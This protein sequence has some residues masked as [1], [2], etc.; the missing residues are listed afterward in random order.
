MTAIYISSSEAIIICDK[1][2]K[3]IA[4]L[5]EPGAEHTKYGDYD[6]Q[7]IIEAVKAIENQYNDARKLGVFEDNVVICISSDHQTLLAEVLGG[8]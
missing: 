7:N 6:A 5:K 4:L 1:A 8:R 2:R 3:I